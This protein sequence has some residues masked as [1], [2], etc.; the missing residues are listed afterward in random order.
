MTDAMRYK[1]R[2]P[3]EAVYWELLNMLKGRVRIFVASEKRHVVSTGEIPTGLLE[4]I[5]ARGGRV[6]EDYTYQL[7]EVSS[8]SA[9][10]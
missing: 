8:R 7:E 2:A 3:N 9:G 6:T 4:S 5:R 1:V 10:R